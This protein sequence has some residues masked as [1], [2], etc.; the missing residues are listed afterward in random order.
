MGIEVDLFLKSSLLLSFVIG[1]FDRDHNACI[2]TKIIT[3]M[4]VTKARKL[5]KNFRSMTNRI[6]Q[7]RPSLEK[8][9]LFGKTL[10]QFSCLTKKIV[11]QSKNELKITVSN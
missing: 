8:I 3:F 10:S 9:F 4:K 1:C 6:S 2:E 11:L 5:N 7:H